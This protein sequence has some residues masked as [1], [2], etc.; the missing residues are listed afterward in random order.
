MKPAANYRLAQR[1]P[2]DKSGLYREMKYSTVAY[3][4]PAWPNAI[5]WSG[6]AADQDLFL[7]TNKPK[8]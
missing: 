3:L 8:G 4:R 7:K 6:F 1:S 2:V 5:K